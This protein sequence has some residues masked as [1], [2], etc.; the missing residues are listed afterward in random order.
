[1]KVKVLSLVISASLLAGCNDSTSSSTENSYGFGYKKDTLLK[2]LPEVIPESVNVSDLSE[3]VQEPTRSYNDVS[4]KGNDAGSTKKEDLI[5]WYDA[6]RHA[7]ENDIFRNF[8][9]SDF[10]FR[11]IPVWKPH[12]QIGIFSKP[13]AENALDYYNFMRSLFGGQRVYMSGYKQAASQ[14]S[15]WS[16]LGG[17][18]YPTPEMGDAL[19][20]SSELFSIARFGREVGNLQGGAVNKETDYSRLETLPRN[21][22]LTSI[23]NE[24]EWDNIAGLAHRNVFMFYP[25]KDVGIGLVHGFHTWMSWGQ[26]PLRNDGSGLGGEEQK[27]ILDSYPNG[28]SPNGV[29]MHPSHGYFPFFAL[30]NHNQSVSVKPNGEYVSG[31]VK[32]ETV[33]LKMEYFVHDEDGDLSTLTQ[34]VKTLLVSD[35]VGSSL[36]DG[37]VSPGSEGKDWV[38]PC[39]DSVDSCDNAIQDR[40]GYHFTT[41]HNIMPL[42]FR[43]PYGWFESIKNNI[44]ESKDSGVTPKYHT[45]RYSFESKQPDGSQGES[46]IVKKPFYMNPAVGSNLT[47]QTTFF[48][49][50]SHR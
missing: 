29:I 17:G 9:G 20:L 32:G 16:N 1:M 10:V 11:D 48:D 34:P 31:L 21:G 40:G 49:I 15:S 37:G 3:F 45:I 39:K 25:G 24:G 23:W 8:D 41:G 28:Q 6:I 33:S 5:R 38:N 47:L 44:E 46:L 4:Q 13:Y 36:N 27:S 26:D 2:E 7:D 19:G 35:V 50:N 42:V 14:A 22:D 12:H 30:N 18:H 43:M